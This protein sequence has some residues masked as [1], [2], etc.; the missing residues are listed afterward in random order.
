MSRIGWLEIWP[1]VAPVE[2]G[3]DVAVLARV[4]IFWWLFAC[5]IVHEFEEPGEVESVGFAYG[6]LP[7]NLLDGEERFTISWDHRDDSVWYDLRAYSRPANLL[8]WLARPVIRYYQGRF[9]PHSL[10]AMERLAKG[11]G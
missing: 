5:R 3:Q 4:M 8:G 9:A 2:D 10:E 6:T 7:G 11:P 1:R